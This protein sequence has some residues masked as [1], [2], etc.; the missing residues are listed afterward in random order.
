[1]LVENSIL[2]HSGNLLSNTEPNLLFVNITADSLVFCQKR[3]GTEKKQTKNLTP[4]RPFS[5]GIV[6][7]FRFVF[8]GSEQEQYLTG[9]NTSR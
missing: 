9:F 7:K 2:S 6:D 3:V 4:H 8:V 5:V 1:M